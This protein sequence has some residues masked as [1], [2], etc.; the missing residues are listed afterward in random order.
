MVHST[1]I[2][3]LFNS[4]RGSWQIHQCEIPAYSFF[5]L[6]LFRMFLLR[7]KHLL[8]FLKAIGKVRQV[9]LYSFTLMLWSAG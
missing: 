2:R 4:S 6:F 9:D 5:S 8:V 1:S 7:L 3:C